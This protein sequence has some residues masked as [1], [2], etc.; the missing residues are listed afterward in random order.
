M[1]QAP[2]KSTPRPPR[3][4]T[5]VPVGVVELGHKGGGDGRAQVLGQVAKEKPHK[6]AVLDDGVGADQRA[7]GP[8]AGLGA[9]H[10]LQAPL[11]IKRPAAAVGG[12]VQVGRG[13]G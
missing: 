9:G 12:G 10:I 5:C 8:A 1:L 11:S 13:Q 4:R 3:G 7:L 2:P 6:A